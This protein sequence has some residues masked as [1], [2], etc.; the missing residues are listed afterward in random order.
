[1]LAD[2][3]NLT[4]DIWV[5]LAL[6]G[7][8]TSGLRVGPGVT[9]PVT[10]QIAVTAS[11]AATLQAGTGG[12]AVLGFGQGDSALTQI[13]RSRL[14][15]GVFEDALQA[16]QGLLRG[17]RVRLGG[18]DAAI[19]WIEPAESPKAPVHVAATGPRICERRRRSRP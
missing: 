17:E 5:S 9:N 2:S 4:G 8:V 3:Q 11:A 15:V 19:H 7:T 10:R 13:G 12:R 16:L 14:S 18:T 1:M 6:A